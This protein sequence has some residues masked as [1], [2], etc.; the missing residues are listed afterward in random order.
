M[1]KL[2]FIFATTLIMFIGN[3]FN[4]FAQAPEGFT[5]QAEARD[6][7]GKLLANKAL[8]VKTTI[9]KGSATDG[10][11]VWDKNYNATTD[12]YGL[13]S[14]VVGDAGSE[15]SFSDI[16]W[17]TGKYFL[18]VKIKYGNTWIN[19]GTTQLLSVPYALY[20]KSAGKA[21]ITETDPVFSGSSWYSTI[22]NS[23]NWNTAFSWGNHASAGY[24]TSFTETDPIYSAIFDVTGSLNGDLLKFDG[25]KFV[26]FTPDYALTT[27]THADATTTVS[28]FMSG[29]D[30]TKLDGIATGAEVN[31]NA[32]WNAIT[33][34]AQILNKPAILE[35]TQAGQMQYWN[36]TAWVIV[37]VGQNGQVLRYRNGVPTWED[38]NINDLSLGDSYQGGI[39]AYFLDSG[40][41]GYDAN[42][43][44]GLI[45]APS[46]QST[47]IQWGCYDTA[48]P[49]ADGTAIGTGN[50][51]TVDI[52]A[53]CTTEGIAAK[54][55]SDLVLNGFSDWYLPS[56][57]ELNKLYLNATVVG[58]FWG[59]EVYWS[60]SEYDNGHAWYQYFYH[61][62][63]G[64]FYKYY[65]CRV[66]AVRAF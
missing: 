25:T 36:G 29:A 4:T 49:G 57:D 56:K 24:L 8:T 3:T 41:P 48:L 2:Y 19:T 52:V 58:G 55:C 51:N 39:I 37:A 11:D 65:T 61:N 26:K 14:I 53:G 21:K 7:S 44:H 34:D 12:K 40:D 17:G 31:V 50:Q 9:L 5:Y 15:T 13:F 43:R 20:A 59:K 66:R 23:S 32:D 1:K 42:V 45:A 46:D 47:G 33:G 18:N 16:E 28:G 64:S 54:L 60:S 62:G 63:Q 22:N 10:I 35:G 38:E 30:K 27:H 6:G